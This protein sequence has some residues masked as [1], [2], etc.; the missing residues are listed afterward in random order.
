MRRINAVV[1]PLAA[2]ALLLPA[3]PALAQR[4]VILAA[5]YNFAAE[6]LKKENEALAG[7]DKQ[8][9]AGPDA[10]KGCALLNEKVTHLKKAE[11][12]LTKM[13]DSANQ[14]KRRKE[15]ENAAKLLEGTKSAV[16][17]TE[18][19]IAKFCSSTPSS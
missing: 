17:I 3:A 19:D 9:A 16:A 5:D 6:D 13:E 18:G 11:E 1:L 15:R 7:I 14:L 2:V 4:D 12:L 10:T 8:L